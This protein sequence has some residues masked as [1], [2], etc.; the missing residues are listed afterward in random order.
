[1]AARS[2]SLDDKYDLSVPDVFLS[3]TQAVVRL[4]LLQAFL[5]RQVGHDTA[6]YVTGYR[7]SPLGGLDQQFLKAAARLREQNI[8]FEPGLNEDLAATALWGTQQAEVRGEGRHDG[9][10]GIWYGKGPGV[11]RSGDA[12]RHANLAGTSRLGGIL[13]LMGDDHTCESSTTAH[14]SEFAFVDA[15]MPIFNPA[16][17]QEILD[18]GLAGFALSRFSGLWTG[19]KCVKDNIESTATVHAAAGASFALPDVSPP[20]G[21]LNI[22]RA[23]HPLEQEAMLHDF[24]LPAARA[25]I[26]ANRFNRITHSGGR[27]P[28]IGLLSLGKSWLDVEQALAGLGIDELGAANFGVRLGKVGVPWPL[29]PAFVRSF[30]DGL[31]LVIVVE[32]KRGLVEP[33]MKEILYGSAN[34]PLIVGKTDES[35]STLFTPKASLDANDI[36]VAIGRRILDRRP[37]ERLGAAVAEI[38]R[39]QTGA[40]SA[41]EYALRTPYFCAGCPHNSST[42]VPEGAR[43]YAGIGCHYMAQWMDR[44]TEGFTQMGGEGAN[45]IGE[46]HFS[47]RGH[48]F[49]NLGDGTYNHSGALALRAASASGANVTYKILFNDAVAMTGGQ[50]HE[51]GLSV[52]AI[53]A[54]VLAEGAKRVVVVS[55]EPAKHEGD[56]RLPAGTKL[57]H[58]SELDSVQRDLAAAE[59]LTVLIYDQTCAAEKRRRRKRGAFP[60]PDR[61]VVINE[62]VCEGC[63]DCGVQS[64]CVAVTAVETEFGRKRQIDQSAC[65]KD[66]SCLEG[67]CPSF[68][69]V[70]GAVARKAERRREAVPNVPE[71]ATAP[72]DEAMGIVIT[73]VGGTGVV[74]IGAI[75]GMAAHLDG[76]GAGIIDMAGLAQKGGAVMSHV[77]IAPTPADVKSIRVAAGEARLVIGCDMVTAASAKVRSTVAR[78][79]TTVVLN[80][81]ETLSGEF[82]RNVDFS[83][84][85]RRLLEALGDAAGKDRLR[86]VDAEQ[87]AVAL[88]GDAIFAN[89]LMLGLAFQ[90]GAL[91]VSRAA[92][93]RALTLNGVAVDANLAAFEWGRAIAHDPACIPA[94]EAAGSIGGSLDHR[95]LSENLD[96]AIERRAN[97]LAAYQDAAFAAR[98]RKRIAAIRSAEAGVAPGGQD[99]ADAAARQLYRMMAQKDEYEVARLYTDG[100]FAAQLGERFADY[101][102]LEFHLAPPI[103]GEDG[104]NG[105]PRKRAFG[106]WMML[107][108][109]ALAAMRRIRGTALDP[110]RYSAERKA[111]QAELAAYEATL[112]AILAGLSPAN[113]QAAAALARWPETLKGFGPVRRRFAAEAEA[114]RVEAEAAFSTAVRVAEAAE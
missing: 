5:D 104:P 61:R 96:E 77:R 31:E 29:D 71:P 72:L 81:H 26:A 55:D 9:V 27:T 8:V 98:Y 45:W 93:R 39:L 106:S 91:P 66:F 112:D 95:R 80:S 67:F 64:N 88:F 73:G 65:N 110:F 76:K 33:Q 12:F 82:T 30:A 92:I 89:M 15:M 10:F 23:A 28:R 60:D 42:R 40:H 36:A 108:F 114:R 48:V 22:R 34:A 25:F 35:G 50:R 97:D 6:G 11:D 46:R 94:P 18:Y 7:G 47:T 57:F 79:R 109:R 102:R 1:M 19:M 90:T 24:R 20:P 87:I 107:G 52:P 3:G 16:G 70:H 59:G 38:D 78:G 103:M 74:T 100:S 62:R 44:A 49:Q 99:V 14:Q 75:I 86:V 32:E 56:P 84:P 53:A 69:T 113:H 68:V 111:E 85:T 54:Q 13:A 2:I 105:R 43:A 41:S 83:F 63:G 21:G 58:R 101:G 4:V 17:V 51:G 37:N